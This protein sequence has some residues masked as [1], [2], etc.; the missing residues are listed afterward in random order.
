MV[1]ESNRSVP[2]TDIESE[3]IGMPNTQ[4]NS[5]GSLMSSAVMILKARAKIKQRKMND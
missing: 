4:K 1:N 5:R 2:K 3:I